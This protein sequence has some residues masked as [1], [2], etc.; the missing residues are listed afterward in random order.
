MMPLFEKFLTG[1]ESPNQIG[2]VVVVENQEEEVGEWCLC[3]L[4]PSL[5]S[6]FRK[7]DKMGKSLGAYSILHEFPTKPFGCFIKLKGGGLI[8]ASPPEAFS[9]KAL[10]RQHHNVCII[11][12]HSPENT[13]ITFSAG[14]D[15]VC[16]GM[17]GDD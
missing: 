5:L 17:R 4:S 16:E 2:V 9:L 12:V 14:V 8:K 13:S 6:E 15:I 7:L 3:H 1:N 10:S 11:P